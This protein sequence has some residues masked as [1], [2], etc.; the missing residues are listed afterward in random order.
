MNIELVDNTAALG[1]LLDT[2]TELQD[3]QLHLYMDLEGNDLCKS[4]TLSIVTILVEQ[5]QT[6][7]LVD[8]SAMGQE[9]FTIAGNTGRTMK[10]M[11]ML[12]KYSSIFATIPMLCTASTALRSLAF[13]MCNSWNWPPETS[14]SAASTA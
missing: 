3:G 11:K 14:P 4:G 9:A 1:H 6:T 7:W 8:I 2:L 10:Q 12:S 13:R 5:R